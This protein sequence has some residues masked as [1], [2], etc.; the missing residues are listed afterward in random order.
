MAMELK[1]VGVTCLTL[2]PGAVVTENIEHILAT[3]VCMLAY[4]TKY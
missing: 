4:N 3:E 1:G 2:Y